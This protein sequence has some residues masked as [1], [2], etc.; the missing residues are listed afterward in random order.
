MPPKKLMIPDEE[1][2][3]QK[4]VINEH[5]YN[6]MVLAAAIRFSPNQSMT[7]YLS[8]QRIDEYLPRIRSLREK[9][10]KVLDGPGKRD[11]FQNKEMN[12]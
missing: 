4:L 11:G 5:R 3:K 1:N 9:N 12:F 2:S 6:Q 10:R 7:S 8:E